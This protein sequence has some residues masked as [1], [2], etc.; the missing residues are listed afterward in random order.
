[1]VKVT[2]F[3]ALC[4]LE[5]IPRRAQMM[6]CQDLGSPLLSARPR[7]PILLHPLP[8]RNASLGAGTG[9]PRVGIARVLHLAHRALVGEALAASRLASGRR[10]A[11][12]T[13]EDPGK[14]NQYPSTFAH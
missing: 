7:W 2:L 5:I 13:C 4:I 11:A 3:A 6:I 8:R 12:A 10:S 1:M 9:K 14:R